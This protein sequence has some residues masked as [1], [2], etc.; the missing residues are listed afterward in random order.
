[1]QCRFYNEIIC[2][3]NM[4]GNKAF[5][6]DYSKRFGLNSQKFFFTET[7]VSVSR[8]N[9]VVINRNFNQLTRFF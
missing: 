9:N 4:E 3:K 2:N 8:Y 1:L 5:I 7:D 6:S